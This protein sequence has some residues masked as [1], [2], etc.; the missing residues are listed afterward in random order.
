[1]NKNLKSIL[2]A[3]NSIMLL[4]SIY[5]YS[6][7]RETEPIITFFGQITALL[8]LLFEKQV[9]NIKTR[10]IHDNSDIEIDVASGDKIETSDVKNSKVKIKTG[11]K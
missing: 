6:E 10:K 5:W 8:V 7:K 4:L 1:M 9:S 11:T 3:I 2:L